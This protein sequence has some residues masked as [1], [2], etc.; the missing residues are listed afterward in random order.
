MAGRRVASGSLGCPI[1]GKVVAVTEG[2]I[3][4]G[5][6]PPPP[7]ATALSAAAIAAFLALEGPGG[8]LALFGAV[9]GVAAEL[10]GLMAGVRMVLINPPA[11][12]VDSETASVL[13]AGRSPL[14]SRS[15]RG[16]VVAGDHGGDPRWTEAAIDAVLPGNRVVVEGA[17][18]ARPGLEILGEAAG[19]WV[20]RTATS[21]AR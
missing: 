9:G 20:A 5:G 1:C 12:V 7:G 10:A 18:L 17:R 13:Q 16:V 15:M 11:G 3:D 21:A 19:V 6:E 4:F 8:Y 14:K 2:T